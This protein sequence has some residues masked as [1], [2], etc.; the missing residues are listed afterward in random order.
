MKKKS[1]IGIGLAAILSF[2]T[3]ISVS[4]DTYDNY[5][6]N[7]MGRN[8]SN[9]RRNSD[10]S[11]PGYGVINRA[12]GYEIINNILIEKFDLTE[13]YIEGAF[14]DGKTLGEILDENNIDIEEFKKEFMAI[15]LTEVDEAV[16]KGDITAE[17]AKTIKEKL[18]SNV[19]EMNFKD[20]RGNGNGR[21]RGNGN[22][23]G[24]GR[25]KGRGQGRGGC[26]N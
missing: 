13:D 12:N 14:N 4:A 8:S 5:S 19:N 7:G 2:G 3:I 6:R 15:R 23:N 21:G 22:G 18:Q 26:C 1:L 24:R 20:H 9:Y 11:C 17:E 25:G 16:K 10:T